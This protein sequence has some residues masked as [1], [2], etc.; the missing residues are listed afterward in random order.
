[1]RFR[2]SDDAKRDLD[3]IFLYWA[4]RTSP[5]IGDRIIDAIAERFWLLGE[6]PKAGRPASDVAPDVRCCPAGKYLIYYRTTR[7]A[8]DILHIFHGA[9]DQKRAFRRAKKESR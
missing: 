9:R 5:K 6:H 8:T 2:I 4:G 1:M 3:E 7:R